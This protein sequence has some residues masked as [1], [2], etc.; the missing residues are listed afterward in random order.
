VLENALH[1]TIV[2]AYNQQESTWRQFCSISTLSDFRAHNRYYLSSFSDLKPVKENGE[3]ED[4]T[5]NDAEKETITG[6]S[7]GRIIN[8]S[9]EII[10][11][12]DMGVFSQIAVKLGQAAARTIEKDVYALL[13][14]NSGAGPTMSDGKAL[15]HVDHGNIGTAA[16]PTVAAFDEGRV[17]MGKQKDPGSNDYVGIRPSIWLGPLGIGGDARVVNDSQYDPDSAN[18][19]QRPNKVRGLFTTVVDTPRLAG[20]AWYLLAD[21]AQE[22][23][24]EVGFLDG[25]QLPTIV[26]EDSFRSNGRAWRVSHDYGTA[27]VGWRGALK[28]A[29]A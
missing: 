3:Y 9:R 29:G 1:K 7:K 11:N 22:P 27:A 16:A 24:F 17:L 4:G 10:I 6:T 28:N 14:L 25:N 15:F 5:I 26:A 18:K 23:V 19:L 8:L 2:N 21:P 20:T 12:D 13:A